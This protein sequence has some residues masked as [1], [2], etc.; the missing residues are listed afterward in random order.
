MAHLLAHSPHVPQSARHALQEAVAASPDTQAELL[1]SAAK[2]LYRADGKPE[3]PD[4]LK[5]SIAHAGPLTLAA[6]NSVSVGCDLEAIAPR[7]TECWRELL[8][9]EHFSLAERLSPVA[10]EAL[11]SSAT[12]VWTAV[13]C[14]K[15]AGVP[16][17]APLV[18][19]TAKDDGWV[20][21][22]SGAFKIATY[23]A[24]IRD[25]ALPHI[26]SVLSLVNEAP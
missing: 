7:T 14:L 10:K 24:N 11:E 15:K 2:I 23:R 25:L 12:R 22:A 16:V 6:T 26:I 20:M 9:A 8:G 13:E 1:E 4:D 18:L 21:L 17:D 19:D 3:L 5:V